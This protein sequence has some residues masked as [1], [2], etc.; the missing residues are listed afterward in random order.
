M[1]YIDIKNGYTKEDIIKIADIIKSGEILI[2]PTDT[3]YG[4]VS[5]S[6][7]EDAVKK[8]YELKKREMSKPL[9]ILVSN[10]EMIKRVVKEISKWEEK[11]I[12]KFFPGSL[13]IIFQKNG[14]IPDIVTS[15]LN[16]VGVRMPNH[17]MLLELINYL[18]N[19]IVATSCNFAGK[20][21]I[22]NAEDAAFKFKDNVK[23]IV[24]GGNLKNGIPSTIIELKEDK[25]NIL[26]EGQVSKEILEKEIK[27]C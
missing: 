17:K 7:N 11:I 22:T 13:T 21:E 26:R 23:A 15:G 2:L 10:K 12:N 6:T 8:I 5:D 1:E 19:P 20:K 4:I 3:V 24:D 16:T 18:D 14:I 25:I 9:N 27:R